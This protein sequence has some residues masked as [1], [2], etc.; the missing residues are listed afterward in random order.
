MV[1]LG[2]QRI[3][4]A[5]LGSS[6]RSLTIP[7]GAKMAWIQAESD[8]VRYLFS[9]TPAA[10]TG[11]IMRSTDPPIEFD[12]LDTLRFKAETSGAILNIQYFG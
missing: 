10:A 12:C 8:N 1:P 3:G 4:A 5:A 6:V 11:L 2:F 9:S 7:A